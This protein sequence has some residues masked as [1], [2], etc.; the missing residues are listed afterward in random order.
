MTCRGVDLLAVAESD[1][2]PQRQ[3][4]SSSPVN[5]A[6]ATGRVATAPSDDYAALRRQVRAAGML[7]PQPRY[8]VLKTVV[9]LAMYALTLAFALLANQL[10]TMVLAG[11]LVGFVWTQVGLLG[12]DVGHRQVVRGRRMTH[13]L[14][15]ILANLLL[16][17]GYTWWTTKHNKHHANPNRVGEDPDVNFS[18]LAFSRSQTRGRSRLARTSIALQA[19]VF[20]ALLLIQSFNMKY[21]TAEHLWRGGARYPRLEIAALAV[22]YALY[23]ALLTQLG[24]WGPAIVFF[25]AHQAVI[26]IYNGFIF[27]PNHKGM[28]MLEPGEQLDFLRE[29]VLTARNVRPNPVVDYLYGG[30]NYQIEHHLFQDMPRNRLHDVQPIVRAFCAE[31]G[32]T[33]E[34]VGA[35]EAYLAIARYLHGVGDHLRRRG[36]RPTRD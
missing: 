19:Y 1:V 16:G 4:V 21:H 35:G 7:D 27:A 8:Y 36:A 11:A 17:V 15:L 29:Q 28:R 9:T 5:T 12:H 20:P 10:A 33:Y 6:D 25:A 34:E 2:A 18:A 31:R 24:G 23:T 26:G 30:L 13:G 3:L 32:I 22:H 14:A